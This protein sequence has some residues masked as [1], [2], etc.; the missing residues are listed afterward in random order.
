MQYPISDR[1]NI[2]ICEFKI[3]WTSIIENIPIYWI[4][5]RSDAL[6]RYG[7]KQKNVQIIVFALKILA[8]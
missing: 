3:I 6:T 4:T 2:H 7:K 5:T 1:E 8:T